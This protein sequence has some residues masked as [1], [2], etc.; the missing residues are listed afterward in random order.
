MLGYNYEKSEASESDP[1]PILAERRFPVAVSGGSQA[2]VWE[3]PY[4]TAEL[5]QKA[6]FPEY[7]L[8]M[9]KK[10]SHVWGFPNRGCW[11]PA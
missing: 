4:G 9:A 3:P 2:A 6:I 5:W 8:R 10:V 11:E 7:S 1:P